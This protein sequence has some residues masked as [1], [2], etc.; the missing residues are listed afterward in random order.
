MAT[1]QLDVHLRNDL[2][3]TVTWDRATQRAT[4]TYDDDHRQGPDPTPLSLSLPLSAAR[5]RGTAVAAYL[6]G[7]LPDSEPVLERW[8]R[9]FRVSLS[10][11]MGLLRAV[12]A[13]LPGAVSMVEPGVGVDAAGDVRWLSEGEVEALL[14]EVRADRTAWLGSDSR[15]SL[16]G[17]QAKIALLEVDGR[18]GRPS[19]AIPTNRILKPAIS[20]LPAHDLNEH[21][22]LTAAHHLGLRSARSRVVSFGAERAV[23]IERYDRS[24]RDHDVVRF[25]QE[26]LCQALG[27]HPATKYQS[28]GGP[29]A[30]DVIGV[31][32]DHVD[33]RSLSTDLDTFVDALVYSWLI[34]APDAHAKNYSMLL[35]GGAVRLAPLYD[36]A[37]VLPYDDVHAPKVKL[38]MKVGGTYRISAIRAGSWRRFAS[39]AGLDPD[40]LLERAQSLVERAPAA[41]DAAVDALDDPSDPMADRLARAVAVRAVECQAQLT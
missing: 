11:P 22:C 39:D 33:Q 24:G 21:L 35:H 38:A 15:W 32:R 28:D 20:G 17:A 25:H 31:L 6:W 10:N 7:L 3:G 16:A 41:F 29:S 13:D 9:R 23:V 37:S 34:A 27:M 26:D 30:I 1:D 19:G 4:F 8:A 36:I 5:H 2:I 12:G 40:R 14:A 18:W